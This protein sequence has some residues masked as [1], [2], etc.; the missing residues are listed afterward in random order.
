MNDSL[1][2]DITLMALAFKR[3][4]VMMVIE[5]KDILAVFHNIN[6][7]FYNNFKVYIL[8]YGYSGDGFYVIVSIL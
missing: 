7:L 6:Q 2:L 8:Y 3:V 5:V 4:N 1:R